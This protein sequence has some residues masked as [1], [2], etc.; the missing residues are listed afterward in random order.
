MMPAPRYGSSAPVV[1]FSYFSLVDVMSFSSEDFHV[2][3]EPF[4]VPLAT[5]GRFSAAG[6][7]SAAIAASRS[8]AAAFWA[9]IGS[10][11]TGSSAFTPPSSVVAVM[12]AVPALTPVTV[13]SA[14]TLATDSSEEDQVTFLLTTSS[15]VTVAVSLVESF[16]I[17]VSLLFTTPVPEIATAVGM[18]RSAPL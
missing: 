15:G 17:R 18:V 5:S 4:L 2:I 16:S 11:V 13:P 6:T 9:F 8:A 14:A 12:V 10:T 3:A 1:L 7:F